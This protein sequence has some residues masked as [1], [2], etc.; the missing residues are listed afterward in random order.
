MN[1]KNNRGEMLEESKQGQP[2]VLENLGTGK[3]LYLESY[4]CQM[5]FSDSE[6][7][8]S[9]LSKDGYETTSNVE[10][11]DLVLLNT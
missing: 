8:A 6:I 10:E 3:K 2:M 7:V 11:A 5:N 9:I 4:G 1:S